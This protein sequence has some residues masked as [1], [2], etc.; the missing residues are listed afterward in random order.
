MKLYACI[1][2]RSNS[3][4]GNQKVNLRTHIWLDL[5]IFECDTRL[6]LVLLQLNSLGENKES[7]YKTFFLP[8]FIE[9]L[10]GMHHQQLVKM[11]DLLSKI[12]GEFTRQ[13]L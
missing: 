3:N 12:N 1:K 8:F 7:N 9:F 5:K 10:S 2:S 4:I 13:R 6:T 11:C